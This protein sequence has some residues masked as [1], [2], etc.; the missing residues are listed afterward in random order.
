MNDTAP[1]HWCIHVL[2][3]RERSVSGPDGG[4]AAE[5]GIAV[6][7]LRKW[8]TNIQRRSSQL[9]DWLANGL[10]RRVWLGG[11]SR[12]TALFDALRQS[13]IRV[14][15][16]GSL[17][18]ARLVFE[19]CARARVRVRVVCVCACARV[20]VCRKVVRCCVHRDVA[21]AAH[22]AVVFAVDGGT[23][24]RRR[25]VRRRDGQCSDVRSQLPAWQCGSAK[26]H[27]GPAS[28]GPQLRY[29]HY[30]PAAAGCRVGGALVD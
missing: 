7:S 10:K 29:D 24:G 25:V 3:F 20:R 27:G 12:P 16:D 5:D 14:R 9:R 19:V 11:V 21:L 15:T 2:L 17:D 23:P 30:R 18:R 8:L 26:G 6:P 22:S 28:V 4:K 1:S 13:A